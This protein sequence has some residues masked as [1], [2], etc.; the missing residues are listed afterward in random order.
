MKKALFSCMLVFSSVVVFAQG[1]AAVKTET[2]KVTRIRK[3]LELTGSGKLGVQIIQNIFTSY[4]TSFPNVDTTFWDELMKEVH[5]DDLVNMVIPIYDQNFSEEEINGML[6][7]YSSPVGQKVL[8]KLPVILNESMQAGKA[9]G[10]E[11]SKKVIKRLQLKGYIK[12]G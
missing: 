10:E 6:A 9:W 5:P 2:P 4:K 1:A 12:E 8:S 11:L 3:I 7:F